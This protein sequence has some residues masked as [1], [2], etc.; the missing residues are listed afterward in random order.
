MPGMA[1]KTRVFETRVCGNSTVYCAVWGVPFKIGTVLFLKYL[2]SAGDL[3]KFT[4]MMR[5]NM[6]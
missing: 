6:Y 1:L 5:T 4:K 2:L 3:P